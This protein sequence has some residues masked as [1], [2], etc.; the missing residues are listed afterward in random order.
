MRLRQPGG[1]L[2]LLV[3]CAIL[4]SACQP[5]ARTAPVI[6]SPPPATASSGGTF[7]EAVA[8]IAGYLN[9]LFADEDNARDID[10]LIYQGLTQ[11]GPDQQIKPLLARE[12]RLSADH[13]TYSVLLR[14]DVRWADG[15]PFTADDV[16][17]TFSVL[18][19][20]GYSLPEAGIWKGVSVKKIADDQVDFT[21]KSPS[22]GF[23]NSLRI[24]IIPQHLFPGDVATIPSSPYSG[25]K[26][27][28]TGPFQVDSISSDR[29]VVT[30]KRNSNAVPAARLDRVV[31]KGYSSLDDAVAAVAGGVADGVGGILSP[32]QEKLLARPDVSLHQVRTFSFT[33]VFL[34]LDP[35]H[36]FFASQSV[37]RGLSQA[38][39]RTALV[40]DV[41][42]GAGESQST[43]I[44]P[45][46][47]AYS[48]AAG[49]RLPYDPEAAQRALDE[50]GWTMPVQGLYRSQHGVDFI[51]ELVAADAFPYRDVARVLQ[52]QLAAVGI[53]VRLN[54]VPA[55]QLVTK[56]LG[57]RSYQM[58]LASLDNGPDPDQ[59]S[60]WHSSE[61]AYPLNF[62]DLPRQSFIDKDLEDG[63][64]AIEMKDRIAAYGDLEDLLVDAAP[65]FFLYEPHYWYA[66]NRR[67]GGVHANPV[68]DAVDRFQYVTDWYAVSG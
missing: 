61:A 15:L 56:Y 34:D 28:G 25:A 68:I 46:D 23:L 29:S 30:L 54:I 53:G 33:S 7:T 50:A 16:R 66:V 35:K 8:G 6:I 44:P 62:S 49:E 55:G 27:I 10:S 42:R 24:G 19:D 64:A 18:Q 51:V 36:P 3:L 4:A 37:R 45:S 39:N 63:R 52:R 20:P 26:A 17:Y 5:A 2:A 43:S 38:I 21:L 47:W 40:R 57:A 12:I 22:A 31:F 59:F 9:P 11:V 14:P 32:G 48:A 41:L 67:I 65:A 58:A 13:L 1:G 60:F